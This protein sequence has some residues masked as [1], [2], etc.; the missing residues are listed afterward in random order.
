MK[1]ATELF[2]KHFRGTDYEGQFEDALAERDKEWRDKIEAKIK[3]KEKA[4]DIES[5]RHPEE[6]DYDWEGCI[7]E[8]IYILKELLEE[9]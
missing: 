9:K 4:L 8:Q 6:R 3:E 2:N 7:R 5:A 1:T